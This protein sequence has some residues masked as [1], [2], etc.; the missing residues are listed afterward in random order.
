MKKQ[1]SIRVFTEIQRWQFLAALSQNQKT[2]RD[3][4]FFDLLFN[5]GLR[6]SEAVHLDVGDVYNGSYALNVL[7]IIG[8]AGVLQHTIP[9]CSSHTN[10][11]DLLKLHE[12][13]TDLVDGW[14]R[15]PG[16]FN[17]LFW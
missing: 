16:A 4:F 2:W 7:D 10:A 8:K 1:R 3:Y 11:F 9:C 14:T 12:S 6:L 17:E 5:T 13:C 15:N